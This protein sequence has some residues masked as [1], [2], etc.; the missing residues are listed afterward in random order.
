MTELL[1][2]LAVTGILA[3]VAVP[4]F[5]SLTA[6]QRAKTFA[7]ELYVTLS[8]TRSDAIALNGNVQLNPA[9]GGWS[10]G[11]QISDPNGNSLDNR[12]AAQGVTINGPNSITYTPS[13]RLPAGTVA[14]KFVISTSTMSATVYQC[15]SIN[16]SGRPY[17]VAASTC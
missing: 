17:M 15:V 7:S 14:P 6:N 3:T 9:A 11:W 5:S 13:G 12:G 10:N 16:L 2:G 1:V 8:K 4:S